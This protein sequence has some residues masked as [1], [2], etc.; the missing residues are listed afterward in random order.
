M[1]GSQPTPSQASDTNDKEQFDLQ[2]RKL[3]SMGF[4]DAEI[5]RMLNA[6]RSE[7]IAP[8][9]MTMQPM[10]DGISAEQ[11]RA[12]EAQVA[13]LGEVATPALPPLSEPVDISV[14]EVPGPQPEAQLPPGA[15]HA[16]VPDFVASANDMHRMSATQLQLDTIAANQAQEILV[17]TMADKAQAVRI[18]HDHGFTSE[19]T[20][21]VQELAYATVPDYEMRMLSEQQELNDKIFR[22]EAY[23]DS[24]MQNTPM[25]STGARY[26]FELLTQQVDAMRGYAQILN[27]RI[28]RAQRV[29]A[30]DLAHKVKQGL[31]P[32]EQ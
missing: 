18:G 4:T 5:E 21:G 7:A 2:G 20:Q 6:Y 30:Y 17:Q 15:I 32:G 13:Q 23:I 16:E 1:N 22:I 19:F 25:D 31:M 29:R 9:L 3:K 11:V 27:T 24:Q 8:P 12:E 26:D 28:A 14:G 10:P